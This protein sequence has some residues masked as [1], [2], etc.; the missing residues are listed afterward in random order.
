MQLKLFVEKMSKTKKKVVVTIPV[1]RAVLSEDEE[2]SFRRSCAVFGQK[3]DVVAF[4]PENMDLSV[5]T[6]I[7][8]E[9]QV[10]RFPAHFFRSI[11]DYSRLLLS[12]E[13]YERF[14]SFEWL[15][16]CQLDVWVF[17]DELEYWCGRDIDF[18]GAPIIADWDP[19]VN[20]SQTPDIVGNGGF[21]LRR[22]SAI[23]KVLRADDVPMYTREMLWNFIRNHSKQMAYH[24]F[25]FPL[26]RMLGI[27][28]RRKQCLEILRSQG[29]C[30]DMVFRVMTEPS[31]PPFL[32]LPSIE[33]AAHFALDGVNVWRYF[34]KT[35]HV[36]FAL[37]AWHRPEGME[38]MQ[39][40][41]EKCGSDIAGV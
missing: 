16:I 32:T 23:L 29:A 17:K 20:E 18:W 38:F 9:L 27:G 8:P 6:S 33:E 41:R 13:F 35:Q 15:L 2:K 39:L 12:E 40:V 22:I 31:N 7:F 19:S 30:E 10:E 21:S 5:Y 3:Y 4:A 14:S 25:L 36:P 28:N 37:H 34:N 11:G 1:Y 24:K 26:L